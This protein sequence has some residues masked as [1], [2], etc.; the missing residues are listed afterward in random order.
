MDRGFGREVP[1]VS[2]RKP[3]RRP[4]RYLLLIDA[5]GTTVVRLFTEGRQSVGEFDAGIEELAP[6]I[7]GLQPFEGACGPEWDHALEG[8]SATERAAA[9]VYRLPV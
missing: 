3:H 8:H 9:A 5:G 7:Q 4:A 6:M 1:A 2:T